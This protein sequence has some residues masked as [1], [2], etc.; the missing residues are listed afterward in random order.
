LLDRLATDPRVRVLRRDGNFNFSM[1]CN[2]G[3]QA[4]RGNILVLLNNDVEMS[5]TTWLMSLVEHAMRP[6]VGAVGAKL[7][8]PDLSVQHAGLLLGAGPDGIAVHAFSRAPRDAPGPGGAL[9]LER[10]VGAVTA[11]CLAIRRAVYLEVGGM[12]EQLPVAY[13]DVDLCLRLRAAG[14]AIVWTPF[15]ELVHHES[16]TRGPDGDA[17]RAAAAVKLRARWGEQLAR[18]PFYNDNL[19]MADFFRPGAPRTAPPWRHVNV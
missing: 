17:A 7:A 9:W 5:D 11:A 10:E 1:L 15:A 8:Y 6:D 16:A 3:A 19:S 18:D 2:A 4:A 14:Y 12:D 13:N